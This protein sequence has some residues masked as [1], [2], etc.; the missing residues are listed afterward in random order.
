MQVKLVRRW[1]H[2]EQEQADERES[3]RLVSPPD[4][5]T[6]AVRRDPAW[7]QQRP[8]HVCAPQGGGG[9]FTRRGSTP[10]LRRSKQRREEERMDLQKRAAQLKA[11]RGQYRSLPEERQGD[12][13][14]TGGAHVEHPLVS[15][16]GQS[17]KQA[18]DAIRD[19]GRSVHHPQ[20]A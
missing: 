4:V 15:G 14:R 18:A 1:T 7:E 19:A 8:E 5:P 20:Q 12:R 17:R 16:R 6:E 9:Q 11:C 13:E 10:P 3:V 2:V